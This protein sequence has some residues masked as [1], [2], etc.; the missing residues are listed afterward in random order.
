MGKPVLGELVPDDVLAERRVADDAHRHAG[1]VERVERFPRAGH[2]SRRDGGIPEHQLERLRR[3]G[4]TCSE[5][6]VD[7]S[8]E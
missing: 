5:E 6:V 1:A 8:I 4:E 7:Q 3:L 2:G